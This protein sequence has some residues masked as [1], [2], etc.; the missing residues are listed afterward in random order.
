[1]PNKNIDL[2]VDFCGVRFPNPFMLSSSPVSNSAEMVGRAFEAGWGGVAYKTL[3][4]DRIPIYHPS[5]RMHGYHYGEKRLVGLQNVEQT[6]DRGLAPNLRD[7]AW[8]KK[9]Y[10]KNIVMAS[11]M[12]FSNQEWADLAKASTDAGADLLELNFSCPHM[13][14]EGSGAKVGQ[15]FDLVQKFTETVRNVTRLPLVAK[16]T[17]NIADMNEPAMAAKRGGADAISA[18]NTVAGISE[19]GLDDCVPRPNVFGKGAMSGYSGPA[20]KPVGLKFIAQMAKNPDLALPLSG[21]GGIETWVDALEYLLAGAST[22]QVTTGIIHYGYRIVEDMIEGLSD[23]MAL[24]GI[25]RVADLVGKAVQ[26]IHETGEFDVMRQGIAAYDLDRCVGCG[27]CYIVCR[28]AGGSA[29]S[30][31]SATRRPKLDEDACLSCMVCSFVCP[32]SGLIGFREMPKTWK[33]KP[34]VTMG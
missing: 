29:L 32:V 7:I 26:N 19:I 9:R 1:M 14:V 21:M 28:D 24:R 6:T 2:S 18:I 30:W 23:Y 20:V 12:G 3:V 22:V 25:G 17:P 15:A 4:T 5:P 27:Q 8:L 31:D 33:R 13:T 34:T 10:P 16:M 11:I